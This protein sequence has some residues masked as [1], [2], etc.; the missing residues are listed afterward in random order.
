[1]INYSSGKAYNPTSE[2]YFYRAYAQYTDL[3]DLDG[4]TTR[5]NFLN[6]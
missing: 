4:I 3:M 2:S 1:M 5:V 6:R